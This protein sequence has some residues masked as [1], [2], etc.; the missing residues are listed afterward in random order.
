MRGDSFLKDGDEED[1]FLNSESVQHGMEKF[2]TFLTALEDLLRCLTSSANADSIRLGNDHL[3]EDTDTACDVPNLYDEE[4]EHDKQPNIEE[5]AF[6]MYQRIGNEKVLPAIGS[7]RNIGKRRKHLEKADEDKRILRRPYLR[8]NL[9]KVI[10]KTTESKFFEE[11]MLQEEQA[12]REKVNQN[13][14][15][16]TEK[17]DKDG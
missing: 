15:N 12:Q 17:N 14:E 1:D 13:V 4:N 9:P 16:N 8:R 2:I 10:R 5:K 3:K 7:G 11:V 6:S